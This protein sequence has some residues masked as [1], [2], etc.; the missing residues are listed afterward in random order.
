MA[1]N[2]NATAHRSSGLDVWHCCAGGC[3]DPATGEASPATMPC[4][5]FSFQWCLLPIRFPCDHA[6]ARLQVS[7]AAC[8]ADYSNGVR[9]QA[10]LPP[11]SLPLHL[12]LRM[13]PLHPDEAGRSTDSPDRNRC[14]HSEKFFRVDMSSSSDISCRQPE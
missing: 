13:M 9:P 7:Y 14:I 3:L 5:T 1:S 11:A 10:S 2:P 8:A 6:G 12:A 4:S